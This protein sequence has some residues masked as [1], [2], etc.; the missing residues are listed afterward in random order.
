MYMN[1]AVWGHSVTYK[2]ND[3]FRGLHKTFPGKMK[4]KNVCPWRLV[5]PKWIGQWPSTAFL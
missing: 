5:D 3:G 1:V 4:C 2:S